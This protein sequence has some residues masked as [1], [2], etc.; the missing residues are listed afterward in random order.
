MKNEDVIAEL[1]VLWSNTDSEDSKSAL[2]IAIGAVMGMEQKKGKWIHWTDDY[3]DY[4]TCSTC[5]YGEEGEVLLK[6]ATPHCPMC[7]TKNEVPK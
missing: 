4:C 1:S 6:N 3:K 7:G 2:D 5:A